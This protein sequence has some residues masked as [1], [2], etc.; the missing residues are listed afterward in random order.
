MKNKKA[1]GKREVEK[2]QSQR[3]K[4]SERKRQKIQRIRKRL[5]RKIKEVRKINFTCNDKKKDIIL[6]LLSVASNYK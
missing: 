4:K 1:K 6:S 5:A 2:S 3:V